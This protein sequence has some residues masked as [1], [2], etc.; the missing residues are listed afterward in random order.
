MKIEKLKLQNV[1]VTA[2]MVTPHNGH[3]VENKTTPIGEEYEFDVPDQEGASDQE[4]Q[5]IAQMNNSKA[6]AAMNSAKDLNLTEFT[7]TKCVIVNIISP[8]I[9][10]SNQLN[11]EGKPLPFERLKN[12]H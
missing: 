10:E 8:E 11:D 4:I 6:L 12:P 3:Y 5:K 1:Q 7:F 9:G 2:S